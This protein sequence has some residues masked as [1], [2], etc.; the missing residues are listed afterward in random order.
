MPRKK[1]Q[2]CTESLGESRRFPKAEPSKENKPEAAPGGRVQGAGGFYR[3]VSRRQRRLLEEAL[4]FL[5]NAERG[6]QLHNTLKALFSLYEEVD[7][8]AE[9]IRPGEREFFP[10]AP[11][12]RTLERFL[13]G[14]KYIYYILKRAQERV[15]LSKIFD[16]FWNECITYLGKCGYSEHFISNVCTKGSLFYRHSFNY[17]R[18]EFKDPEEGLAVMYGYFKSC[19]GI[20]G[21]DEYCAVDLR[22]EVTY[23]WWRMKVCHEKL[24]EKV[25]YANPVLKPPGYEPPSEETLRKLRERIER[26]QNEA[27]MQRHEADA[28]LKMM[29]QRNHESGHGYTAGDD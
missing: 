22:R 17:W 6:K 27:V 18:H 28:Y 29:S 20:E 12:A 23:D 2:E 16:N 1:L 24:N 21:N 19:F 5:G 15:Y 7:A 25:H 11:G 3:E 4:K 13:E 10:S 26:Y 14:F 9:Y 8:Y